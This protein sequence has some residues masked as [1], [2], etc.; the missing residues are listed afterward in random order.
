M[1]SVALAVGPAWV[2]PSGSP[3]SSPAS[4]SPLMLYQRSGPSHALYKY[5]S[6]ISGASGS[7]S[8]RTDP[9]AVLDTFSSDGNTKSLNYSPFLAAARAAAAEKGIPETIAEPA[10]KGAEP[11]PANVLRMLELKAITSPAAFGFRT[12]SKPPIQLESETSSSEQS[13]ISVADGSESTDGT[14]ASWRGRRSASW[15]GV[16]HD[17]NNIN[18]WS[19]VLRIKRRHVNHQLAAPLPPLAPLPRPL[20]PG[21]PAAPHVDMDV[22]WSELE[23]NLGR[24]LGTGGFGS[25]YEATWRG[26]KVAVKM[27]PSFASPGTEG[28]GEQ[29]GHGSGGGQAAYEALLREIKLAS[30]FDCDRLVRVYGACTSDRAR[31][32]LIMELVTGGNLFQ[33]IYDRNKRRLTYLEIL[34]LAHDMAEGLAY[35]HPSV[36]HRDLKPQNILLDEDGRA[37]LAD[38]GISRVKDP[39]KSYITQVTNEN[40]TPVYMAPELFNG[41]RVDEKV[42]VYALGCILNEA[43]TRRQPWRDA[44]HFFQIIL[45]VA[46]NGER[47]WVDPECPESLRRLIMKCWHQDPHQRP[48]CADIM[49]LTDL[50][51]REE[52]RRWDQLL[53]M[54]SDG[55]KDSS[56][57]TG[58]GG[59]DEVQLPAA[60]WAQER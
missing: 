14:L 52:L 3:L 2:S 49:R 42:D 57:A 46:I 40:G 18:N 9:N 59:I 17:L 48:S 4:N 13:S 43:Y 15:D 44:S 41:T 39:T 8:G 19:D 25:V 56:S 5:P 28:G 12:P 7:Q 33:R 21:S 53:P 29:H 60:A 26:K 23:G 45:K 24:C 58:A 30:M 34:Q 20:L 50:L 11:L 51:I 16:L 54:G 37:K 1:Q 22:D 35:L 31:C 55:R 27:L 6:G 38:F 10:S 47:P 36:V 32:C